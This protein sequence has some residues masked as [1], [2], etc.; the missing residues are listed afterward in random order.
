MART[1][2]A[3]QPAAVTQLFKNI[4]I[5]DLRTLK[6]NAHAFKLPLKAKVCHEGTH[7]TRYRA[8]RETFAQDRVKK[9]VAVIDAPRGVD[10]LNPIGI[11]I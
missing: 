10:H 1:F 4:A 3:I 9:F 5:A 8:A 6:R 2:A 11:A 7:D